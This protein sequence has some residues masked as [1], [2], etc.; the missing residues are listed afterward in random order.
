MDDLPHRPIGGDLHWVKVIAGTAICIGALA[1]V[2][3][4]CQGPSAA[5]Q[6]EE[7]REK[8]AEAAEVREERRKGFHCLSD[9]D[10]NHNGFERLVKRQLKDPDSMDTI[11]TR[12]GPNEGGVHQIRM[13]FRA[14]N[15]F[16]GMTIG[17]AVGTFRNNGCKA[18][19]EEIIE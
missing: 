8:A 1:I 4:A 18:T 6:A 16:G 2:L 15:S 3:G 7:R 9:W 5:E 13:D 12:V 19:L 17:T 10:G 14:R 11:E